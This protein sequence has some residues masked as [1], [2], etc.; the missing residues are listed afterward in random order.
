MKLNQVKTDCRHFKG[1]IP[2]KPH[3][4]YGV[5]CIDSEGKTC[6]Y[7]DQIDKKIL[8]IK[9]GAIGD[10][11]RTTPLFTRLK[12]ENPKA[13]F[14]WL[15][16]STEVIPAE[17]DVVLKFDYKSA[18]YLQST[19]FDVAINL[20]KDAEACSL[21]DRI[22]SDNKFGFTL[23]DGLTHPADEKAEHKFLTGIFDDLNQKNTKS[24]LEEIF[25]ICGIKYKGEKYV[26][27]SFEEFNSDWNLPYDKKIIGL[28]TGC[29]GRWTTRLWADEYWIK[30]ANLLHEAGYYVLFLGGEQENEKNTFISSRSNGNYL[31][32]FPLEKFIN[33]V[34][35]CDLVVTAVTMAMHITLALNKKIV[36]FNNIFN[37]NEFELFGLGEIISPEKECKCF[38]RPE[39]I[40]EKYQ[41]MTTLY[42]E[43]VFE[44]VQKVLS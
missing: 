4:Q 29:G 20:D 36:L 41:C 19:K 13:K 38:F 35:Q 22:N 24:Y 43:K 37:P 39:C 1:D 16:L 15:T 23:K 28:N 40:N 32:F 3:K 31:G 27:N 14:F 10:V 6:K 21:L 30:L 12:N 18:L 17:V 11:I 44:T 5:H 25:E 7:Y 33:L 2:C 34:N 42:P 8:I 26:L 9:L